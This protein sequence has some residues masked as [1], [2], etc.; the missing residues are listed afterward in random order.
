MIDGLKMY[1][2]DVILKIFEVLNCLHSEGFRRDSDGTSLEDIPESSPKQHDYTR[3][4]YFEAYQRTDVIL[5][6]IQN[7][8]TWQLDQAIQ[9]F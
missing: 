1:M 3:K 9:R 6:Q 2:D 7:A 5:A 8:N 4:W